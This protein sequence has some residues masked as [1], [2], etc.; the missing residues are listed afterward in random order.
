MN[1]E[2]GH[3][4][5]VTDHN[6]HYFEAKNEFELYVSGLVSIAIDRDNINFDDFSKSIVGESFEIDEITNIKLG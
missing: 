2:I 6:K 4:P 3:V 1:P 5:T